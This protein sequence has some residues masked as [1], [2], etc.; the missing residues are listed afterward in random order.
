MTETKPGADELRIRTLLIKHGVG[1]DATPDEPPAPE[2]ATR[3]RDWLDDI[4]EDSAAH[5]PTPVLQPEQQ[6]DA[7]ELEP[8]K[9]EPRPRPKTHKKSKTNG[10]KKAVRKQKR[11]ASSPFD[12]RS[13]RQSLLD[14]WDG[15]APRTRWLIYHGTA[16]SFGWGLGVVS[17]ATHVTA[18]IAADRWANPQSITCYVLGLGAVAL[19]RR[20]RHWWWPVA[21]MA[22]VPVSS[23]VV[24]VLLYAPNS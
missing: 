13:P 2:P 1:P 24:G 20:T 3:P 12:V 22:A 10:S 23:I 19:Y 4:L 8:E 9:A 11:Q 16:A 5:E 6:P 14:A 17:W 7:T 15:V 18:W 21:W